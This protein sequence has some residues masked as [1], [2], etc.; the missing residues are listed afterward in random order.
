[1]SKWRTR[2]FNDITRDDFAGADL[3]DTGLVTADD[4]AHFGFVFLQSFNGGLGISF[5]IMQKFRK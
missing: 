5:L 1:M 3:L 4:L 2:H